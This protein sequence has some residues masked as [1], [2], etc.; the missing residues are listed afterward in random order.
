MSNVID[1]AISK[2]EKEKSRVLII[3]VDASFSKDQN[4]QS[5]PSGCEVEISLYALNNIKKT[6][7]FMHDDD[8]KCAYKSVKD[9]E[10]LSIR[11]THTVHDGSQCYWPEAD[12]D[13]TMI[14][15]ASEGVLTFETETGGYDKSVTFPISMEDIERKIV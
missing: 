1:L 15:I 10:G 2:I 9:C 5:S 3:N 8:I 13:D 6:L 4:L 12:L 7:N 14:C 11:W